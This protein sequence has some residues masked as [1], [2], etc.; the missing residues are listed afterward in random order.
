MALFKCKL[1]YKNNSKFFFK[2]CQKKVTLVLV[3]ALQVKIYIFIKSRI[4]N[5]TFI[6]RTHTGIK[7]N[8]KYSLHGKFS[9][10]PFKPVPGQYCPF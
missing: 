3:E 4:E 9:M 10:V 6:T 2:V 8:I 7:C 5:F 1:I